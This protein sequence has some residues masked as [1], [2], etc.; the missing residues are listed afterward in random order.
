MAILLQRLCWNDNYW[1]G[2]TGGLHG[3]EDSYVGK[4]GF[5]HEEWNFNTA[6]TVAGEV[7]GYSYYSPPQ[8]DPAKLMGPHDIYFFAV[9]P[10][11]NRWL[12]GRYTNARFLTLAEKKR[13]AALFTAEGLLAKRTEELRSLNLPGLRSAK[14]LAKLM[15]VEAKIAVLPS[16][17]E[18]YDPPLSLNKEMLRG[19]DPKWLNRYTTPTYL[20][21]PP[22]LTT[23]SKKAARS[24][25]KPTA[26]ARTSDGGTQDELLEDAYTRVSPQQLKVIRRKHNQLSNLF[27][28]TIRKLGM[29]GVSAEA[30]GVDVVAMQGSLR[31]LFELKIVYR[32]STRHSLREALGQVLEY[33]Y[34]PSRPSSNY[35]AIVLDQRPSESDISWFS[36][37]GKLPLP[38]EIF[39]F[40]GE[41]LLSAQLTA[42]P[43]NKLLPDARPSPNSPLALVA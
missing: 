5:G 6:E 32:L 26:S 4:H 1:R 28:S 33:S 25:G 11:R 16:N 40:V 24:S 3:K 8:S 9:D 10:A 14:R 21:H 30:N 23:T 43:L 39:Y 31:C 13:V 12:V 34:Y 22:L 19:R 38:V 37:L 36:A 20:P 17:V 27:V 29:S 18:V 41:Q 42:N 2:P 7:V 15:E 35:M